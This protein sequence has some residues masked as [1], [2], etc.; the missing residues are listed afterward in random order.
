MSKPKKK[1]RLQRSPTMTVRDL[2]QKR[3]RKLKR[4]P[5]KPGIRG[6]YVDDE[7][8]H[9]SDDC[10]AE[11]RSQEP[12]DV[13][14]HFERV[15]STPGVAKALYS[16]ALAVASAFEEHAAEAVRRKGWNEGVARQVVQRLIRAFEIGADLRDLVGRGAGDG[17]PSPPPEALGQL[18][19]EVC[20]LAQDNRAAALVD[21]AF[22]L[23]WKRSK[24]SKRPG[25]P[26]KTFGAALLEMLQRTPVVTDEG[27]LPHRPKERGVYYGADRVALH[28]LRKLTKDR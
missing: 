11:N 5:A 15:Y 23:G 18:R 19:R 12:K 6:D 9:D 1:R 17:P 16:E 2:E 24:R 22:L 8:L 20:A 25:A 7:E 28:R 13:I 26:K 14:A 3:G 10:I 27:E 4:K 21:H